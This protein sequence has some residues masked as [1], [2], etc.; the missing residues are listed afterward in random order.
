MQEILLA[1]ISWLGG[2]IG[3]ENASLVVFMAPVFAILG[4]AVWFERRHTRKY[5]K[6]QRRNSIRTQSHDHPY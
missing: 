1:V 2:Y 5:Y 6:W 4:L 3:P